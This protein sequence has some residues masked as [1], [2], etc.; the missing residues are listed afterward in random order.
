MIWATCDHDWQRESICDFEPSKC[1][2]DEGTAEAHRGGQSRLNARLG[3]LGGIA[4]NERG[5]EV[6]VLEIELWVLLKNL[7]SVNTVRR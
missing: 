6:D 7:G 5:V 3:A 2:V 4:A 1:C